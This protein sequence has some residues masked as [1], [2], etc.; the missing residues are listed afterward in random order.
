MGN[1]NSSI[2]MDNCCD[3]G[4]SGVAD[5]GGMARAPVDAAKE[6]TE[7]ATDATKD[8]AH[9]ITDAPK[10]VLDKT[11]QVGSDAMNGAV[12][13]AKAPLDVINKR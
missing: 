2:D 6:A 4:G 1:S 5:S 10:N 12:D 9:R 8:V 7:K 3:C 11:T 13:I